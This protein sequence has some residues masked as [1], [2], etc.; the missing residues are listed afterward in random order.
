MPPK[1]RASIWSKKEEREKSVRCSQTCQSPMASTCENN[2]YI[3][4]H[5]L[6]L[7]PFSNASLYIDARV[8]MCLGIRIDRFLCS[9]FNEPREAFI[10]TAAAEL[11]LGS[12]EIDVFSLS[13]RFPCQRKLMAK[14]CS[15]ALI[16]GPHQLL[17]DTVNLFVVKLTPS[18]VI[19]CEIIQSRV[20]ILAYLC[21]NGSI[22]LARKRICFAIELESASRNYQQTN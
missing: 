9:S 7:C 19:S 15:A 20:Y 6:C 14:M 21:F 13:I 16:G 1:N 18:P 8:R 10:T 12:L 4:T 22:L 2:T 17:L 5:L 3:R 11:L